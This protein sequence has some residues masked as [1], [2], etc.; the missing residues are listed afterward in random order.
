MA[1]D[2]SLGESSQVSKKFA[3]RLPENLP[4]SQPYWLREAGTLGTYAVADQSL[5][6][7]PENPAAFPI[8]VTIEVSGVEIAYNLE[9]RFRKLDRVAG[10]TTRSLVIAPAAFVDLPRPVFVFGN[11]ESKTLNVRVLASAETVKGEV[12][13]D[14]PDGWKIEPASVPFE[15]YGADSET[16]AVFHVTPPATSGEATLRATLRS[17]SGEKR[18]AFSRQQIE[19]P[20]IDPQTL[21]SPA[22][23]QL[24]RV[25]IENKA[26][27]IGYL[28]GAGDAIPESLQEIGSEVKILSDADVK[29]EKLARFDAIVLGVRVANVSPTRLT[30]WFPELLAYAKQGGVVIYQYNTTPGPKPEQLP[31]PLKVSRDRVT[32]EN[33]EV[34]ILAPDHPVL[35]SPNKIT[36]QDFAGWVQERGL[37]F[38]NEWDA[39]W[40]PIISCHDPEEKPLNG[41]LLVARVEKGWFVYTGYSWFREL[42]A[43]VP[44]AYRLFANMI[45]LGSAESS[46]PRP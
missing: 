12:A 35:N 44:G 30:T 24:V 17:P 20:H 8:A 23:A 32:D 29:A 11:G 22:Q 19:Y 37:Y 38:P 3:I 4:F 16:T 15:L 25:S 21:I 18:S 7:R 1:V 28:P 46:S 10:E 33:A 27:L 41:G 13:L 43:G 2:L 14:A 9:P 26:T 5:I 36:V 31:F 40:T 6:G 39:A 34:R 42:P 45:S